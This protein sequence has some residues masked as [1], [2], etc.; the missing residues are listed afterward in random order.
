VGGGIRK[1]VDGFSLGGHGWARRVRGNELAETILGVEG[2]FFVW[3]YF[4]TDFQVGLRARGRAEWGETDLARDRWQV[5][6]L[7]AIDPPRL[8]PIYSQEVTLTLDVSEGVQD[9]SGART[10]LGWLAVDV[11]N[12]TLGLTVSFEGLLFG[13]DSVPCAEIIPSFE[14]ATEACPAPSARIM[15]GANF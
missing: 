10:S 6:L 1:R 13:H 11:Q 5:S 3:Q 8:P 7:S 4:P 9:V 15:V 2:E 14:L 12:R